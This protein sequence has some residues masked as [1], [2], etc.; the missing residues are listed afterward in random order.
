MISSKGVIS[1]G[2]AIICCVFLL[3]CGGKSVTPP[4]PKGPPVITT[5]SLPN[6]VVDGPYTTTVI[7]TG[8]TGTFTWAIISGSLPAGL[9]FGTNSAIISGTP[10]GPAGDYPFTVQVTDQAQKTATQALV[11][12]VEGVVM[13]TIRPRCLPD[14][15]ASPT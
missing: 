10:T 5:T 12:H 11:L 14:P 15:S 13:I 6:A 9:T 4:P 8:G 1:L 3:A 7:A 2:L